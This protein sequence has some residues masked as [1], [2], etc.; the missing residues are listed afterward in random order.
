[1][2]RFWILL[3]TEFLVWKGDPI[4]A[5]GGIIP[6]LFILLAFSLLF[7]GRL[8][9]PIAVINHDRGQYGAILEEIFPEVISPLDN[10]PYYAVQD[11]DEEQAWQQYNS[12]RIEGIWIIPEDFSSRLEEGR[13]PQIDMFFMNYNDDRAK[14]HRIYSSEVLWAFYQRIGLPGPPLERAEVYPLPEMV[15]WVS[16][17]SVGIALLA[18][19]LGAI[20]NMFVLT[21]KAQTGKVSLEWGLSP[22][23]LSWVLVPKTL[24]AAVFGLAS[25]TVFLLIIWLWLGFSP[26][27]NI[28]TVWLLSALVALFWAQ[29]ALAFG[30]VSRN[31][32]TGAVGSV[33]GAMIVFFIGG[34]LSMVR[35]NQDLVTWVAWLFPNTYAVDPLRDLILFQTWPVDFW[36]VVGIL[37]AFA[38]LGILLG[39]S[40]FVRR[41]RRLD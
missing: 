11:L 39:S 23:S 3:R 29:V 27:L 9:F 35:A 30:L 26:G 17:I 21:Y 31:Y 22:H 25:G 41:I 13:T 12:Y 36:K 32:M 5:L 6:A 15:D 4:T 20:F 14:N 1:M 19:T 37:S 16:I 18:V 24:L 10:H 38:M 2:R 40:Y 34:G 7:G 28:W 33:L 8:S